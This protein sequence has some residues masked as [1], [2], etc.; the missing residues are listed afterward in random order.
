MLFTR[1]TDYA[2]RFF[3][4]LKDG[5]LHSVSEITEDQF[6]PQQFAYKI[7]RKLSKAGYVE[8]TRGAKGG[9]KL[10]EDLGNI[11]VLDVIQVVENKK[12]FVTCLD[13][14]Y[15]CPYKESN[16]GCQ[17]HCNLDVLEGKLVGDLSGI[18]IKVLLEEDLAN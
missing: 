17:V 3:R 12:T 14:E 6:I 10:A 7:L 4:A 11:T 2:I 1:E 9:C 8:V 15:D 5:E 13:P 18:S 16:G